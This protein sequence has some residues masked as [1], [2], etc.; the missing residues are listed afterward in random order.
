MRVT[1]QADVLVRRMG[2][3][4]VVLNLKTETYYLL[5]STSIRMWE[6][7]TSSDSVDS[8]I[9][10][11]LEEYDVNP[12]EVRADV[13]ALIATLARAQLIDVHS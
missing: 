4:A 13:D 8:A 7:L 10:Q 6:V 3:E 5:N 9:A 12:E 2:D 1:P 11:L